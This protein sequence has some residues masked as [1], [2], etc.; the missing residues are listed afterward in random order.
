MGNIIFYVIIMIAM[1]A[2]IIAL[3]GMGRKRRSDGAGES[4]D[5]D[6]SFKPDSYGDV[7][8]LRRPIL[9]VLYIGLG[10]SLLSTSF[11]YVGQL[12]TGHVVKRFMGA[13]LPQGKI[14]AVNGETGPQAQIYGPGLKFVPLIRLYADIEIL[15]VVDIPKG[16]Y[17]LVTALD[18]RKL[19]ED[20]VIASPLPG[21]SIA[22]SAAVEGGANVSDMFD[23]IT[24]LDQDTGG[25]QG[26]QATVLKPGI[27]RLN[28][29]LYNV[30]V[31]AKNGDLRRYSRE[32]VN[33]QVKPE[34][35]DTMITQ[36]Q[37]GYVGVVK[38]NIQGNCSPIYAAFTYSLITS[39][40][41]PSNAI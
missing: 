17:G 12:E 23:A 41:F 34:S 29:Y 5:R 30:E 13:S 10:F 39:R 3:H 32:G 15:P 20:V 31:V 16:Y 27:H 38:S 9:A 8:F 24:F 1:V 25:F 35:K 11:F 7:G 18:G 22:P 37:T 2:G 33:D 40:A 36:I 21:T 26:V 28:L 14:I 4:L 6:L 19:P